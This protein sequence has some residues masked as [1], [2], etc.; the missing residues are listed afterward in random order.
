METLIFALFLVP[1][2]IFLSFWKRIVPDKSS[3]DWSSIIRWL[4]ASLVFFLPSKLIV[5]SFYEQMNCQLSLHKAYFVID[6]LNELSKNF[7][8]ILL[9]ILFAFI[10]GL[11]LRPPNELKN[12][13]YI[14]RLLL[15]F[16]KIFGYL[17]FS[18]RLSELLFRYNGRQIVV[19]TQTGKFYIGILKSEDNEERNEKNS[20]I[21]ILPTMSGYREV[22]SNKIVY[23][24][25][26]DFDSEDFQLILP[27]SQIFSIAPF[28]KEV[29]EY[30]MSTG[31]I[32]I[33]PISKI[34]RKRVKQKK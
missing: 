10:L 16:Y 9:S 29:H 5:C 18:N 11:C 24:T 22:Q 17:S 13:K 26:Y 21:V 4:I 20:V 23:D 34:S 7:V 3:S 1:G 30:F 25:F 28:K 14:G 8:P 27:L 6:Y 31:K 12:I 15:A 2:Y 33:R 19:S 32:V